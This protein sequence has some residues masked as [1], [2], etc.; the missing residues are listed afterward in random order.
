MLYE[1]MFENEDFFDDEEHQ[2]SFDDNEKYQIDE[3]N[4][5]D[6]PDDIDPFIIGGIVGGMISDELQD[7][8]PK[9]K[10]ISLKEERDIL[11]EKNVNS[12]RSKKLR[13]FEQYVKDVTSG[14]VK[15]D[16]PYD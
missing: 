16:K 15:L 14:K 4:E 11:E 8:I 3:N 2:E 13:P 6:Y 9:R 1:Y 12:N 5:I 7:N 10:S